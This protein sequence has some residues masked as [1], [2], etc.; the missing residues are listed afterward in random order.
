M[1]KKF[2]KAGLLASTLLLTA[3]AA[4]E[5]VVAKYEG[6]EITQTELYEEMK[7]TSGNYSLEKLILTK[8][9]SGKYGEVKDE[10]VLEAYTR[11][12]EAYGDAESFQEMLTYSGYT[13]ETYKEMIRMNLL[14]EKAVIAKTDISEADIKAAYDEYVPEVTAAHILVEDKGTAEK[15]IK[16]IKEGG[17]FATL[18]KENSLD[19]GTATNGGE[20]TF[21]AG[22]MVEEFEKAAFALE[23]GKFTETPVESEYGFHVIKLIEKPEKGTLEEEKETI[24]SSLIADSLADANYITSVLAEILKDANVDIT[25]EA[26][27][28]ALDYYLP[29]EEETEEAEESVE[30][31]EES[32][33]SDEETAKEDV[34]STVESEEKTSESAE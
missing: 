5:A 17:D 13:E 7:A 18:A 24:E 27:K 10:D 9:L 28:G 25:D 30:E 2:L 4:E 16:Q 34:E 32:V 12:S 14:I 3:C 20:L 26:L 8:V 29:R 31:T 19:T 6:G 1:Y 21:G 33:D 22:E 11:D 23:V 15:L